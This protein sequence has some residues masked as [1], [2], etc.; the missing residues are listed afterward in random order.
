MTCPPSRNR[1]FGHGVVVRLC[2]A[3]ESAT[4][5]ATTGPD[6]VAALHPATD[7]KAK[8]IDGARRMD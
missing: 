6:E 2:A 7:R 1:S 8:A 3:A 4:V 5:N